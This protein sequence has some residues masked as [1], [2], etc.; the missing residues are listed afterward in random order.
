VGLTV[1]GLVLMAVLSFGPV[2]VGSV[3]LDTQSLLFSAGMVTVGIQAVLFAILSRTY[4]A[5]RGML[6][7]NRPVL[8][9]AHPQALERG[10]LAGLLLL[11]IG[12]AGSVGAVVRWATYDFGELDLASSL[13]WSIPAI[14]CLVVGAQV[15]MA[16]F[17]LGLLQFDKEISHREQPASPGRLVT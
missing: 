3:A 14:T 1:V 17:F 13:R 10:A 16:S 5:A 15:L 6:P 8:M 11:L 4:A 9:T 7:G 12:V 2:V